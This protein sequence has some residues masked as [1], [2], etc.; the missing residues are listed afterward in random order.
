MDDASNQA[1]FYFVVSYRDQEL[2]TYSK[3]MAGRY[4]RAQSEGTAFGILLAAILLLGLVVFGAFKLGWV[5]SSA[6]RPVLYTAYFAFLTGVSGYYFVTRA[7]FRKFIRTDQRGGTWNYSFTPTGICY[8]SETIEVQLAWRA[9]KAVEDLGRIVI[10][11]FGAQ[12]LTLPSRVFADDATR[13][14]FTAAAR[15]WIKAA[16]GKS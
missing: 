4:A 8:R 3:M 6:V 1:E 2:R 5:E 13:A 7:Y 15:A 16:A 14:A 10:V 11:R 9:V 12:G